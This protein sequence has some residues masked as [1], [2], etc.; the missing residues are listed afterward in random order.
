MTIRCSLCIEDSDVQVDCRTD[1]GDTKNTAE[2]VDDAP[3]TESSETERSTEPQ[4]MMTVSVVVDV[5]PS[6]QDR[7]HSPDDDGEVC[8]TSSPHV[9]HSDIVNGEPEIEAEFRQNLSHLLERGECADED[10]RRGD[11]RLS[12]IV[13]DNMDLGLDLVKAVSIVRIDI[14]RH[15]QF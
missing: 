10:E 12:M 8:P 14:S 7:G 1:S 11:F 2:L 3:R 6:H 13:E 15:L 5:L 9:I 4:S